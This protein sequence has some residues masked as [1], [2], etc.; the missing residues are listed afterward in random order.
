MGRGRNEQHRGDGSV[1]HLQIRPSRAW[2]PPRAKCCA[3]GLPATTARS[4]RYFRNGGKSNVIPN[5]IIVGHLGRDP[6]MRYTPCRAG[7]DQLQPGGQPPVHR[8]ERSGGERNHLVPGIGLGQDR[9][10]LQPVSC[11]KA[12]WCWWKAG[13]C[14][15]RKRAVPGFIPAR[16]A[17]LLRL[18]KSAPTPCASCRV[19]KGKAKPKA[20]V[21]GRQPTRGRRQSVLIYTRLP[22]LM[23]GQSRAYPHTEV[24][25]IKKI[26]RGEPGGA[27]KVIALPISASRGRYACDFTQP[28]RFRLG[29]WRL[30][31]G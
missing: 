5:D 29:L 18:S 13:W 22:R 4:N 16:M 27:V 7:R 8:L 12:A 26:Y 3:P 23:P 2:L 17:H 31:T 25:M 11:I 9:R 19:V 14:A 15:T 28:E 24:N 30:W 1:Q 21:T 6:E 10:E 20:P